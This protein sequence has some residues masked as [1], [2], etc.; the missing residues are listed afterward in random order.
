M[1]AE[2]EKMQKELAAAREKLEAANL[3]R[4][5]VP[6]MKETA[7]TGDRAI[8]SYASIMDNVSGTVR[9]DIIEGPLSIKD[10]N[11][12]ANS[13]MSNSEMANSETKSVRT[14]ATTMKET[15]TTG[16]RA[17]ESYASIV[18]N[19]F[20]TVGNDMI[21][22][23]SS[24]KDSI[25]TGSTNVNVLSA[26]RKRKRSQSPGAESPAKYNKTS[27]V[28]KM[29]TLADS[30]P[31]L[32][33]TPAVGADAT[34]EADSLA[35]KPN[36]PKAPIVQS[37]SVAKGSP[38]VVNPDPPSTR[39][40]EVGASA[41]AG[42]AGDAG[43][44]SS[45]PPTAAEAIKPKRKYT[46]RK[47]AEAGLEGAEEPKPKR[48]YKRKTAAPE[49]EPAPEVGLAPIAEEQKPKPKRKYTKRKTAEAGLEGAEEP[50][51]KRVYK[52]KTPA[53]DAA[54]ASVAEG[55]KPKRTY[56]RKTPAAKGV[57]A[58]APALKE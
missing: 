40:V 24:I 32:A 15:A 38:I 26:L 22:G 29:P 18:D 11:K 51:P 52:R 16:G 46:K 42:V 48:V 28:A 23:L 56:K 45:R 53:V 36:T 2:I 54:G 41:E 4:R 39:V 12:T 55:S 6:T 25:N 21:E 5:M 43:A 58:P 17:I 13:E 1:A 10:I 3:K 49:A 14:E 50:K 47:T 44:G 57:P 19:V 33:G 30:A 31:I 35:T 7:T 37:E 27:A 9:N 20:D 34:V 8:E